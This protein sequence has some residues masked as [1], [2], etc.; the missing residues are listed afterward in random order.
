M[1]LPGSL[2]RQG[3]VV[4]LLT[5][6]GLALRVS[7]WD[8]QSIPSVDGTAY[9]R[10]ARSFAGEPAVATVHQLGYP[11]LVFALHAVA[12]DW[13]LS[14][15]L[16][17]LLFGVALVPLVWILTAQH[18]RSPLLRALP[19]AAVAFL[20]TTVRYSLTTM[21]ETPYLALLFLTF[22]GAARGRWFLA[23]L[24]GG[25]AY[26]VR[27]EALLAVGVLA[28]TKLKDL[29]AWP[30]IAAG[31]LL[32][33]VP[34]VVLVG[35][36]EGRWTLSQ[37]T[38]DLAPADWREVERRVGEEDAAPGL[39]ARWRRFG[40]EILRGT[41]ERAVR[42]GVETLRHGGYV[43]PFAGLAG[44]AASPGLLG[45]IA[46]L[47]LLP[48]TFI[49]PRARYVVPALPFFWIL[50]AAC[51]DRVKRR[52][53]R[54]AL[55]AACA[56]GLAATAYFQRAGYV[57]NEDGSFPELVKAG[58]W[59][60]ER[61]APGSLVYDRKP[62]TAYFA[63]AAAGTVPTGT[64][65]EVLDALVDEGADYLVAHEGVLRVFRPELLP[66][67]LDLGTIE[68]E[69]RVRPVYHDVSESGFRTILYRVVRP[70]GPSPLAEEAA[71]GASLAGIPHADRHFEHGVLAV[72]GGDCE[73]G[74]REL[75]W[76]LEADPGNREAL[77]ARAR[78]L[79]DLGADP[80]EVLDH[81]RRAERL[82]PGDPLVLE[83][84]VSGLRYAGQTEEAERVR[85]R[86]GP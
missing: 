42:I 12:G 16:V 66:L 39:G 53:L 32:V 37:K 22:I 27:P 23:G 78:C 52:W 64:Y 4:G 30:R 54:L 70:G 2:G 43:V 65:R 20:P 67:V 34:Y 11:F 19:A 25:L 38:M 76:A 13:I 45:G 48:L 18:V 15:R 82:A 55:L 51:L 60:G 83:Y 28:L 69:S 29:R 14:A 74:A 36:A 84:L 5:A 35:L 81:L 9:L 71:I 72:L 80:G 41:P 85:G 26:A 79:M 7:L 21:T 77:L 57:T 31:A 49:G 86:P 44:I 6:A 58:T 73:A 63:G 10:I 56:A 1:K 17:A 68:N 24:A 50:A 33:V 3:L 62:Y 46:Y 40:P 59:L 75:G 8:S 47:V 61:A